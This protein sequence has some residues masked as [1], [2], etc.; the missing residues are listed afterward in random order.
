[1]K[2]V[3]WVD[4]SYE[5][6]NKTPVMNQI[7]LVHNQMIENS[8]KLNQ[9][10]EGEYL[11]FVIE[12]VSIHKLYWIRVNMF[13][14]NNSDHTFTIMTIRCNSYSGF[15]SLIDLNYSKNPDPISVENL[16]KL[17]NILKKECA[18]GF[19]SVSK[20]LNKYIE[21][22]N[23]YS[24]MKIQTTQTIGVYKIKERA[25]TELREIKSSNTEKKKIKR[26]TDG[27]NELFINLIDEYRLSIAGLKSDSIKVKT[28]EFAFKMKQQFELLQERTEQAIYEHLTY[29]DDL[30]A[31]SGQ[32]TDYAKKDAKYFAK[33]ARPDGVTDFNEARVF[34]SSGR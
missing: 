27:E 8:E 24:R 14:K 2:R 29:F 9:E 31:G 25:I 17:N 1:M 3:K 32:L 21:V 4:T 34:R 26:W 10:T 13:L 30:L 11:D 19:Q 18:F 23:Q 15:P 28:R 16:D 5:I 12:V 22:K 20:A 6:V 33:H 7:Q